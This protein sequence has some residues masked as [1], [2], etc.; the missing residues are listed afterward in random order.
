MRG[1]K[2]GSLNKVTTVKHAIQDEMKN[3]KVKKTRVY[4]PNGYVSLNDNY[5]IRLDSN[6][7]ILERKL[8]MGES[9]VTEPSED[10]EE[11]VVAEPG[12]TLNG[13]FSINSIGLA[14]LLDCMCA[15]MQV[16]KF[17]GKTVKFDKFSS[18]LKA[19]REEIK[20]IVLG[21]TK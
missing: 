14:H 21:I 12:W 18:E 3:K 10:L 7:Y 15:E 9:P 6:N 16:K 19:D 2:V 20:K 4:V 13:Y 5:R 17:A 1:R 11:V 8:Q